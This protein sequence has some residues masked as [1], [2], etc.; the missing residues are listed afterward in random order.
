METFNPFR[1]FHLDKRIRLF[2]VLVAV[3]TLSLGLSGAISYVYGDTLGLENLPRPFV[4]SS[5]MMNCSIVVTS[6]VGHGPCGGAHTMDVMGAI[7]VA[8]QLGL[9]TTSGMLD[10]TMDDYVS[11][12]DFGTVK[13]ELKDVSSN[14]IVVGGPGV[15]QITWYY[16][17]LRNSSGAKVLPVFFDKD[18]NG[19]DYIYV[20]STGHSY[21]IE[22][23]GL[24]RVKADYGVVLTFQNGG[25]HILILAGLGGAGTWAS[26]KV[27]SEFE[28]WNL[29]GCAA[30]VKYSDSDGD[31]LLNNLSIVENSGTP[32]SINVLSPLGFGMLF[33]A[34]L[35][36][37]KAIKQKIRFRR[38]FS[39]AYIL[40]FLAI[41]SQISLTALSSDLGPEVYTF[42]DFSRPF[43]SSGGLMNCSVVVASSVGH[44]PCGSAHTMDV[45]G[46]IMVAAQLGLD[47]G[48]GALSSTLDD[49][50]SVYDSGSGQISFPTLGNNLIV[51]GGPGVNQVTWY[52]NNLRNSTGARVL[53]VYFD[54]APNGTDYIHVTSTG[55]SYGIERDGLGRVKADY[56]IVTLYHDVD[57]GLWVLIAAGLGGSGTLAG[58]RLL[59]S[60]KSWSLFGQAAVVKFSDSNGDGYLDAVSIPESVGYGKSI[61]VY[62]DANCMS[63][64][65]SINWGML[66]PGETKK[67][68]VYVRNEG[69]RST[70]LALSVYGWTPVEALNYMTVSWNYS[71]TA[72][73]PGQMVI[74]LLTLMVDPSINGITNFGVTIDV[75]SS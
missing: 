68:T 46:A 9:K 38:R 13:V 66:S 23:D 39:K 4:S 20:A 73:Y 30:I 70:V 57:H 18:G 32:F 24:G 62:S 5:G 10:A 71:G 42:K 74:I 41:A 35:S 52:Y 59:A 15:N 27:V 11:S 54:K 60:Y 69:E 31:G 58:S 21:R 16:N 37:G 19:V 43:I 8:A 1:S 63:K 47:A 51:V 61:D 75:S 28:A 55:H 26:C 72:V 17:N 34:L 49:Y 44:G 29:H 65:E 2:V 33:S 36:K 64:I 3:S 56:G 53:P 45:M 50:I 14:L 6:S 22:R 40:L 25:R 48:G 7:I 12:Y 67:V